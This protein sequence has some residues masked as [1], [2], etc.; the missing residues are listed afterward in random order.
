MGAGSGGGE[1]SRSAT[2]AVLSTPTAS[3]LAPDVRNL[4]HPGNSASKLATGKSVKT[5]SGKE[6]DDESD[7]ESSLESEDVRPSPEAPDESV[8]YFALTARPE[9]L[10]SHERVLRAYAQSC[11]KKK[12]DAE[13]ATRE[14]TEE[15][16][17]KTELLKETL[18][19]FSK[20]D[21]KACKAFKVEKGLVK[22]T[23]P[24]VVNVESD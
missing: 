14:L 9:Q 21:E 12:E 3:Y 17:E 10:T 4:S 23:V 11:D 5:K 16:V 22:V 2:D 20:A 24:N 19:S 18:K 6:Y 7:E 1:D 15:L 13:R 8:L